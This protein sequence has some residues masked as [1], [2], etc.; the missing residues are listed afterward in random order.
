MPDA[1]ATREPAGHEKSLVLG[2][3]RPLRPLGSGGSGSVWLVH[4]E[5]AARQVALKVVRREGKAG[6][7]AEREVEAAARLRH[8]HCLRAL[9]LH[10]DEGHVYV[11]YEYVRGKTLRDALRSGELGDAA[12]IEA[13]AQVLEAIAHAHGKG[14]VHRDVKPANAMLEEGDEVSV[15]LLDFGLAHIDDAETLTAV[16]DVPG[17][18]AYV[19][20]ERLEG[21]PVS[22]AAD[23]WAVGV[24]LWEALAGWHPFAGPSPVETARRISSGPPP[25][26]KTRPDLPDELCAVIHR[27]L[28]RDPRRRPSAKRLATALRDA[29][30]VRARRPK[31]ATSRRVLRERAAHAVLAAA[32]TATTTLVLPFFPRGWPFAL[33]A[34]AGVAALRAPRAGL[35]LALAAPIL[36]LAN[37]ALGLALAYSALALVWLVLFAR[38][39]VNGLLFLAGAV[40]AP[41]GGIGL[42]PV[43]AL[44]SRGIIRRAAVAACTVLAAG[45]LAGAAGISLPIARQ[46]AS[47]VDGAGTESPDAALGAA[48]S[49]L[50]AQPV[51]VFEAIALSIAAVAAPFALRRGP[52]GVAVWGSALLAVALLVPPVAGLGDSSALHLA[53]GVILGTAWLG[54]VSARFRR[55]RRSNG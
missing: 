49:A 43:L 44:R 4:D 27:M 22:G 9:D 50:A 45:A 1:V 19:A 11:A 47:P 5:E 6:S 25:L 3:Y 48:V 55:P 21:D 33:A 13:A 52:W 28:E 39:A 40:L 16:G 14:V 18:L 8:P 51:L 24:I 20:P 31:P 54:A 29:A 30:D 36:P 46:A 37:L 2:R 41:I 34:V 26:A 10:R 53:P 23:V 12:A 7:R 35:A 32:Y 42:G 15:R 17:T 38:D